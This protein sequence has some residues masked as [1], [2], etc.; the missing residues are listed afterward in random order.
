[1]TKCQITCKSL[2][3]SSKCQ[4]LLR[5][6]HLVIFRADQL[7]RPPCTST[8]T[9]DPSH[10]ISDVTSSRKLRAGSMVPSDSTPSHL[11]ACSASFAFCTSS[12]FSPL[13]LVSSLGS[14]GSERDSRLFRQGLLA[15]LKSR[16]WQGTG[17]GKPGCLAAARSQSSCRH[18]SPA[19]PP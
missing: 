3:K 16:S 11:S 4:N 5:V 15:G 19:R 2:Q 6:W 8:L 1:M 13:I 17:S 12:S 9:K 14:W 7:K 10:K 18:S